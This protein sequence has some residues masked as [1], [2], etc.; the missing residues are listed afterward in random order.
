M[1]H[2]LLSLTV[3]AFAAASSL[4][5]AGAAH[6][7]GC[8]N[9]ICAKSTDDGR[10]V[11]VEIDTGQRPMTHYNVRRGGQQFELT[12]ERRRHHVIWSFAGR[13]GYIVKYHVQVC[14]RGG[15][16]QRSSCTGWVT[17]SHTMSN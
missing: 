1:K 3:M 17:F 4:L 9:D 7:R 2:R 13:P 6:A 15:L 14:N 12:S 10:T 11:K 5:A 16:F 8:A